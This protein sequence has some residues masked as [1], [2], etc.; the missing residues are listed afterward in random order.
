MRQSPSQVFPNPVVLRRLQAATRRIT[1]AR[2]GVL[3]P[4]QAAAIPMGLRPPAAYAPNMGIVTSDQR[5][6]VRLRV[7]S[8]RSRNWRRALVSWLVLSFALMAEAAHLPGSLL[9]A[10]GAL[11]AAIPVLLS[12][13]P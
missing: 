2:T 4:G 6:P 5:T 1:P 9:D 13:L 8:W 3:A 11:V 12:A 10:A 7:S